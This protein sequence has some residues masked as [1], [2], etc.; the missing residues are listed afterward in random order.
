MLLQIKKVALNP[1]VF[2]CFV[3]HAVMNIPTDE[4]LQAFICLLG[5]R[6]VEDSLGQRMNTLDPS[7]C[8]N[9]KL[10]PKDV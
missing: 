3:T 9:K 4:C 6:F 1:E 8:C 2:T 10:S 5:G 7:T